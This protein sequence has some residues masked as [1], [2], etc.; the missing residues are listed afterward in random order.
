[1]SHIGER[2]RTLR[3]AAGVKQGRLAEL[4]G[5]T[6]SAVSQIESGAIRSVK[7]ETLERIARGLGVAPDALA[8]SAQNDAPLSAQE[9]W[10]LDC[11]R[12]LSPER[13]EIAQRLLKALR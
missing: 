10:L 6:A 3:L 13:Q 7:A 2:I 12:G 11:Y 8:D 5:I 9:Q 4:A 1:M